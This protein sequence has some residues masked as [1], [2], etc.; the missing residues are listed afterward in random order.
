VSE[1]SQQKRLSKKEA[2]GFQQEETLSSEPSLD[3]AH[4]PTRC[5]YCHENVVHKGDQWV[6]CK[7][8][9]AKHHRECWSEHGSCSACSED[10]CLEHRSVGL[11]VSVGHVISTILFGFL[12]IVLGAAVG[13]GLGSI[14]E[15]TAVGIIIGMMIG[16][17]LASC[18]AFYRT[19]ILGLDLVYGSKLGDSFSMEGVKDLSSRM[20]EDHGESTE[21]EK[22][23]L[24]ANSPVEKK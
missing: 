22:R 23:E 7:G 21:V 3:M 8:C 16:F 4:S 19:T 15:S 6:L 14:F 11:A 20:K 17:V 24:T 13:G 5:P 10:L 1:K 18:Y 9:L 12:G 2:P